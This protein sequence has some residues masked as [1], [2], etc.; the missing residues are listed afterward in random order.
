MKG[1][2]LITIGLMAFLLVGGVMA[3]QTFKPFPDGL[4]ND[5]WVQGDM[6][7]TGQA[8][9]DNLHTTNLNIDLPLP[10]DGDLYLEGGLVKVDCW[11]T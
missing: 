3:G 11:E 9:A 8:R 1:K 5:L 4:F 7:V 6:I 2:T 10:C